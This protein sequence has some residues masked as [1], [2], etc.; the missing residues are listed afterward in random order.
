TVPMVLCLL[1]GGVVSDRMDRR[2]VMMSADAARGVA[3]AVMG[4]L[5]LA[6]RLELWHIVV[7]AALYGA[8]NAF[9]GPSFDAIVPDLVPAGLL[10]EANSLD[11]LVRPAVLRLA[12]P[13]AGGLVIAAA[14][15]G[16]AF[17]LDA[18]TFGV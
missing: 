12:G 1:V 3:V 7:A 15:P 18:A 11:Q 13:A 9:F 10:A 14:G 6:G 4:V 17:L 5:S 2:R 8:A 16:G